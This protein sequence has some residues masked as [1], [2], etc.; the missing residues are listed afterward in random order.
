MPALSRYQKHTIELF[1]D[2]LKLTVDEKQR[3]ADS[4]EI[5]L[6]ESKGLIRIEPAG[7]ASEGQLMSEHHAC[8]ECGLSLPEIE[9]RLFSFNSPYGA[10]PGCDGIQ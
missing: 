8:P 1:V 9:P 4:V 3:V 2:K 5:A 10:C 7:K 6:K